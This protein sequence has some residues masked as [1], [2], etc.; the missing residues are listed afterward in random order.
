MTRAKR[1]D[2]GPLWGM[3]RWGYARWVQLLAYVGLLGHDGR[4]SATKIWCAFGL[5]ISAYLGWPTVFIVSLA[6]MFGRPTFVAAICSWRGTTADV[7]VR[8]EST[9]RLVDER[10]QSLEFETTP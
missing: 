4:P 8:T 9:T 6:G 7:S 3:L 2:G 1:G 5:I 10:R